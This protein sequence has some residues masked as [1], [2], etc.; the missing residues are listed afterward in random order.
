MQALDKVLK[1]FSKENQKYLEQ[2]RRVEEVLKS[3]YNKDRKYLDD[4]N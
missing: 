2:L 4:K 3:F 1:R